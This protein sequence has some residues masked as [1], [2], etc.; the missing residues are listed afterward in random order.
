MPM[1]WNRTRIASLLLML[2]LAGCDSGVITHDEVRASELV[3]DFFSSLKSAEGIN[4]AYE[5]SD[6]RYKKKVKLADFV[7]IV[8]SLRAKN[9]RAEI[10]LTGYETFG[11]QEIFVVYAASETLEGE[12][13]FKIS[14]TGTKNKDYYL[15][16]FD[17]A[18]AEFAKNGIYVDFDRSITIKGV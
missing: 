1:R 15:L 10:R 12:L 7:Q 5:W 4:M 11:A 16:H 9:A 17:V 13:Y 3:V 18:D 2:A 14:L 8:A 6:D